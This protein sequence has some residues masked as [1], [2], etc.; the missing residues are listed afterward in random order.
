MN[1]MELKI[2][3][4]EILHEETLVGTCGVSNVQYPCGSV[5]KATVPP[6]SWERRQP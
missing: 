6:K 3:I 1:L 4:D 5:W 2:E